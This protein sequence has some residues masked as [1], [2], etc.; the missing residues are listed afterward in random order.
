MARGER[1]LSAAE[2]DEIVAAVQP[3]ID[4]MAD[5]FGVTP[6]FVV[7]LTGAARRGFEVKG[8]REPE[9]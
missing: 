2:R 4:K 9:A 3:V 8:V 7:R 6:R 5:R 1:G